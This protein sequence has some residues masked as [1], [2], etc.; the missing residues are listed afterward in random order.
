MATT[1]TDVCNEALA[2][3]GYDGNAVTGVAPNF[4]SSTPGKVAQRTYP[5]AVAAVGR[6]NSWSFPRTV[7]ELQVA[8]VAPFPWAFQYLFPQNCIDVWQLA[9]GTLADFNNPIPVSWARGIA[10]IANVQ[11]SVIWSNVA[12]AQAIF[13]SNPLEQTWDPLFRESVVSY[14]A[15]RFGIAN[16]GK[17]DLAAMYIEQW[18]QLI[19]AVAERTDQ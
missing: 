8:G 3:I 10:V 16:L 17:P 6:L 14:L 5:Y 1:S 13:N 18:R 2:W 11:S 15:A 7:A 4:D 19:P 12:G 9:P